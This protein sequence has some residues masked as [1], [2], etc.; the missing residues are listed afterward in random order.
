MAF[1]DV[2]TALMSKRRVTD[3]I[4]LDFIKAFHTI[5]PT[6]YPFLQTGKVWI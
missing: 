5:P 2:A 1:Y 4:Y 3:V 6:K